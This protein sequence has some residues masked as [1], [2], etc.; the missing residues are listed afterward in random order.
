[1]RNLAFFVWKSLEKEP[2]FHCA[3]NPR[4]KI[5]MIKN[6]TLCIKFHD[7]V[8]GKCRLESEGF[9]ENSAW[10]RMQS[11]WEMIES[12]PL[13]LSISF[14]PSRRHIR[15]SAARMFLH[16]DEKEEDE[17]D[18]SSAVWFYGTSS[19]QAARFLRNGGCPSASFH[20]FRTPAGNYCAT[21]K[22]HQNCT[23][24]FN[25]TGRVAIFGVTMCEKNEKK[26]H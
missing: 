13:S 18:I 22:R 11:R 2:S 4:I 6:I 24:F 7:L 23:F 12:R 20:H 15:T 5:I 14:F 9:W 17:E 3:K 8:R 25:Q 21:T 26:T 16:C 19:S 10:F 1:M